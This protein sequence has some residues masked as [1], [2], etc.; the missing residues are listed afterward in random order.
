[1]SNN[2]A[3]SVS[4]S[5]LAKILGRSKSGL[6]WLEKSGHIK[7]N[8]L[9]KFDIAEVQRAIAETVDQTMAHRRKVRAPVR[10][11][12]VRTTLEERRSNGDDE[13]LVDGKWMPIEQAIALRDRYLALA[14][15]LKERR[16]KA[17][18]QE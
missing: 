12:A 8:A 1:M 13:V 14:A 5:A 7:R 11:A 3:S 18:E 17:G 10:T 4:L 6:W 9:G 2:T 15:E 16:E